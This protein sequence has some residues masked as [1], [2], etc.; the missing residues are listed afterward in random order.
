MVNEF[1]KGGR[2][3]QYGSKKLKLTQLDIEVPNG[4]ATVS[5]SD[6]A[7]ASQITALIEK[8][9]IYKRNDVLTNM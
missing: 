8:T 6:A 3:K 4:V 9:G 5:M 1:L 7:E 2:R